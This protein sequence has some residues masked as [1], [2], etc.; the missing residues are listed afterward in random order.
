MKFVYFRTMM[1]WTGRR[2]PQ[3][4]DLSF[5]MACWCLKCMTFNYSKSELEDVQLLLSLLYG[6]FSLANLTRT[7]LFLLFLASGASL[8]RSQG[9]MSWIIQSLHTYIS[10]NPIYVEIINL[11]QDN[12]HTRFFI[13]RLRHATFITNLLNSATNLRDPTSNFNPFHPKPMPF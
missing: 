13:T 6:F 10:Y 7:L 12:M 5:S 11:I 1:N 9:S 2:L 3:F 4:P 8:T